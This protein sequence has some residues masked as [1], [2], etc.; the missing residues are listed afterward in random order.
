MR[1]TTALC[2]H[3]CFWSWGEE[4]ELPNASNECHIHRNKD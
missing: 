3:V 4:K 1:E 2:E